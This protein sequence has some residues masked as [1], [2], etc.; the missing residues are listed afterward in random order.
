MLDHL[1]IGVSDLK[2]SITFYDAA[3][4]TLV[5]FYDVA[6]KG[7]A[8]D[9]GEPGLRPHFGDNYFA[10]FIFDPD[11]YRIEVVCHAPIPNGYVRKVGG[12]CEQ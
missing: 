5:A 3:F 1:S 11:G 10:A 7:G 4:A 2:R 6:M 8:K 9:L 12:I